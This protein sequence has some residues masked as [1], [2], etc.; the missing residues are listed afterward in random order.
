VL[1]AAQ[2]RRPAAAFTPEPGLN[3]AVT[4]VTPATDPAGL[5]EPRDNREIRRQHRLD[6]RGWP[7]PRLGSA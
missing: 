5:D 3:R 1:N 6:E 4:Q 2:P 7:Q